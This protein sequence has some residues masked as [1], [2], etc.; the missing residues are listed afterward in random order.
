MKRL[1]V[2]AVLAIAGLAHADVWQRAL[3]D[4]SAQVEY[5]NKIGIGD[6]LAKQADTESITSAEKKRMVEQAVKAYDDAAK[7]KPHDGEPYFRIGM[8]LYSF[9]F[10]ECSTNRQLRSLVAPSPLCSVAFNVPIAERIITAWDAFEQRAPLDPRVT[11]P[12][13]VEGMNL[14]FERA[15]LHTR[16]AT[17]PHLEAAARDYERILRR[18]DGLTDDLEIVWNNLAETY[19]MLGDL[20]SAID[21]YKK[22]LRAGGG[23]GAAYGYAVALDRDD[24]P[25]QAAEVINS[26]SPHAWIEFMAGVQA[27]AIF[28]VPAGEEH[29]YFALVEETQGEIDEA[30]AEWRAFIASGAHPEYQP[31]AKAHIEALLKKQH[32]RPRPPAPIDDV[33]FP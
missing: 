13:R 22:A 6:A 1:A 30:I 26:Q 2:M 27:H 21:G 20:D 12:P 7:A 32:N 18:S 9:Y 5:D 17:K 11:P 19:M 31:R 14:L 3:S 4:D 23:V 33:I 25:E 24:N 28:Y 29:Y 10:Q 8:L 15:I 16:I